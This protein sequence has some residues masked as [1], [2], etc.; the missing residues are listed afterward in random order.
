[1]QELRDAEGP[2]TSR[3]I[4]KVSW[5]CAAIDARDRKYVSDLTRRVSKAL[6]AQRI[7]SRVSSAK[8]AF[9]NVV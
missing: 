1:M 6:R 4:A 2:M 7:K 9:D 5:R 8:D 3:Q